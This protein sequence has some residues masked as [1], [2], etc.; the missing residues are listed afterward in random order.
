MTAS[1]K[2]TPAERAAGWWRNLQGVSS[3]G[4][5]GEHAPDRAALAELR[6]CDRPLD[7]LFV[8]AGMSLVR[9]LGAHIRYPG[10]SERAHEQRI[11]R[12][13]GLASVLAQVR[14]TDRP[15]MQKLG[16]QHRGKDA[17]DTAVLSEQRLRRALAVEEPDE[18]LAM[19]RRLVAQAGNQ[20]DPRDLAESYLN[21]GDRV[22]TRWA[23]QYY[24]ADNAAPA[25]ATPQFEGNG[26]AA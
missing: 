26:D 4:E 13:T 1:D 23:F 19:F 3:D 5:M 25:E 21:W 9:D 22:R 17:A 6:R 15:L 8:P 11:A 16:W 2:Q 12:A 24:A 10:E 7:A 18:L 20:C 14:G